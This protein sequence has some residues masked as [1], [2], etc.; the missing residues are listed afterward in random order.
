VSRKKDYT[1]YYLLLLSLVGI[2]ALLYVTR[3]GVGVSPDSTVY[4]G[5]ARSLLRGEGLSAI[6]GS[7]GALAPLTHYPPLYS[8]LL[9]IL[10]LTGAEPLQAARWTNS[11]IFGCN[12]FLVGYAVKTYARKSLWLPLLGAFLTLASTDII[13][14]H[15]MAWTEP[16][17]IFFSLAGF[18]LLAVSFKRS[19]RLWLIAAACA[20]SLAF[21]TRYIGLV[22]IATGVAGVLLFDSRNR[23]RRLLDA[24]LFAAVSGLPMAFWMLRNSFVSGETTDRQLVFHPIGIEHI[25]S[26]LSTVSTWLLIGRFR[27]DIRMIV[28]S[29]EVFAFLV[30]FFFLWRSR[31]PE[32]IEASDNLELSENPMLNALPLLLAFFILCYLSFLVLTL[33]FVDFD[34]VFDDRAL[35]PVHV[36]GLVLLLCL[37]RR[38]RP[39]TGQRLLR[40]AMIIPALALGGSQLARTV[41]WSRQ[42]SGD[43]Q[44]YTSRAWRQSATIAR[45]RLL[46]AETLIYTNAHDAVYFLSE[47]RALMIPEKTRHGTGQPNALYSSEMTLMRE[48]LIRRGGVL[49]YFDGVAERWYLPSETELQEQ[50]KLRLV[51][52]ESDGAIYRAED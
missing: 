27:S 36:F 18:L 3:G 28:F 23:L 48:Q 2:V 35:L 1:L 42:R 49:V 30:L 24:L 11:L 41:S 10:W 16:L 43:G 17:F 9:A 25:V 7:S 15:S 50:L 33:S 40:V 46:P 12:I 5:A 44:G 51:S 13:M 6:N 31:R 39:A 8:T 47:R 34:T 26:A 19:G 20:A 32:P 29:I 21:L 22:T 14:V 38:L 37:V 4:I 52:R 45:V